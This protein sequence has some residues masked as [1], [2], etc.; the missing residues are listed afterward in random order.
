MHT[1]RR[2]I[3]VTG[4]KGDVGRFVVDYFKK[5]GDDVLGVDIVGRGNLDDYI[6]ADLTDA[7]QVFDVLH[8]A[9]TVIHLGAISDPHAFPAGR[10]FVTNIAITFNIFNACAKLG[11]QRVVAASSI[12]IH[13]PAFPHDPIHY[14]YLPFDEDHPP[15]AHDEYGLS[16]VT[17]EAC[18]E[19]FAHHWGMTVVSLRITWSVPPDL[20][21][22]FP[23]HMPEQLSDPDPRGGR[24]LPTPFYVDAR[25]CARACYLAATVELPTA[26][27]IPLIITAHDSTSDI[28]SM[29][30]ARRFFPHTEVRPGLDGHNSI[31]SGARAVRILGFTPE[32][33]WR[34]HP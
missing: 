30:I 8:D 21:G 27:H 34:G 31:C 6:S 14:A 5:Q 26:T 32:Y 9:D 20:M 16:K 23:I 4:S 13:H 25:D 18:A 2:R 19:M 3:V 7:G 12:Q 24:W 33:S 22:M 1:R 11:I 15:D 29:E 10:T 17:G 28:P